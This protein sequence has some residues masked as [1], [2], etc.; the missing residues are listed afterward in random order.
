MNQ[1]P[2]GPQGPRRSPQ[3]AEAARKKKEAMQSVKDAEMARKMR[4]AYERVQGQSV[5]GMKKGGMTGR[6]GCA[7][8][9][10]TRA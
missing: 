7:I 3:Q 2:K 1:A 4:E 10:R 9:G 5:S 8:R 6:D